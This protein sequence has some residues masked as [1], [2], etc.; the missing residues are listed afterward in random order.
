MKILIIGDEARTLT[1]VKRRLEAEGHSIDGVDDG[2]KGLRRALLGNYNLVVLDLNVPGLDGHDVLSELQQSRS[3]LP[4]LILSSRSGLPAKLHAFELGAS[5]YLK[6]PFAV[7]ELIA[8]VRA[9]LRHRQKN[10]TDLIRAGSLVLDVNRRQAQIDSGEIDL[11]D[12]EFRLLRQLVEHADQVVSRDQLLAEV[13]DD[14][15]PSSNVLEA[16][17]RRLRNK[18]GPEAHIKTV[19]RAGYRL[20]VEDMSESADR[21]KGKRSAPTRTTH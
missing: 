8:R 6:K 13:W 18:L 20:T 15:N 21:P 3:D 7:E 9:Q 19:R 12:R 1:A 4:V 5:D 10:G 17:I 2:K 14:V 11:S 16:C